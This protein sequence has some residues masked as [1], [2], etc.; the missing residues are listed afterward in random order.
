MGQ[1]LPKSEIGFELWR[2]NFA[3][4]PDQDSR[5]SRRAIKAFESNISGYLWV[6][7]QS[8]L[9]MNKACPK[10]PLCNYIVDLNDSNTINSI[11]L[12]PL[13]FDRRL[14][15]HQIRDFRIKVYENKD[16]GYD[17]AIIINPRVGNDFVLEDIY[18]NFVEFNKHLPVLVEEIKN[19]RC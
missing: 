6:I 14:N 11:N 5:I 7:D 17:D 12:L 8:G 2:A 4:Y 10:I 16:G 19:Q 15:Q 9:I 13:A 18:W 3:L 1:N